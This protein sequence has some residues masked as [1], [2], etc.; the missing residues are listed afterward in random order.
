MATGHYVQRLN[1]NSEAQLQ[2]NRCIKDQSY[3][4]F[5]TTREQLEM[6]EFPLAVLLKKKLENSVKY[7]GL[8]IANKPDSQDMFCA[9]W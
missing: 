9:K 2:R 4:L 7:Y 1:I 8:Q 3:F 5:T 6:L